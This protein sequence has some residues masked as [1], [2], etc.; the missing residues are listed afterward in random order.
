MANNNNTTCA[1]CGKGYRMCLSCDSG[2]ASKHWRIHCDT[3]EHYKIFQVIH[4]YTSGVYTKAEAARKLGK[5]D[6]SDYNELRDVV[7][8]NIDKILEKPSDTKRSVKQVESD[9]FNN[10]DK[11]AEKNRQT[12][13]RPIDDMRRVAKRG[14][15]ADKNKSADV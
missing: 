6:L 13:H 12:T 7:K 1:I 9:R 14:V 3:P 4:G 15:A 10:V 8:E 11:A 5:I 2:D